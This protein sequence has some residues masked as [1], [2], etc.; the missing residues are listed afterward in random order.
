MAGEH[1]VEAGAGSGPLRVAMLGGFRVCVGSRTV[2]DAW[3][4]RKSKTLVK[5]LAVA[6]GHRVHRDVLTEVL[7]PGMDPGAAA[8]NLHQALHAA[9]RALASAGSPPANVLHLKDD[10]VSLSPRGLVV[11]VDV[12]AAAAQRALGSGSVEDYQGALD[13]YVGELPSLVPLHLTGRHAP[14]ATGRR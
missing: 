2:P 8:N 5:L 10:I 11:D 7:W 3:R 12:F 9:R 14:R 13:L 6:D 1:D 4:L